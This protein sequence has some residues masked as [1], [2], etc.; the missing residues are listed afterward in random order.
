MSDVILLSVL[1]LCL[2][3]YSLFIHHAYKVAVR[4]LALMVFTM[5]KIADKEVTVTRKPDGEISIKEANGGE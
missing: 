4:S 1:C 5:G 3:A 2:C